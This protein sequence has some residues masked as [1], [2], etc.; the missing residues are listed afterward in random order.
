MTLGRIKARGVM[1]LCVGK[2]MEH[3]QQKMEHKNINQCR[4]RIMDG[5]QYTP[6][7]KLITAAFEYCTCIDMLTTLHN[8]AN[9]LLNTLENYRSKN[10]ALRGTAGL[11]I[12]TRT[13]TQTLPAANSL[14]SSGCLPNWDRFVRAVTLASDQH[15]IFCNMF[16]NVSICTCTL[17]IS[18][19]PWPICIQV[20]KKKIHMK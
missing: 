2:V 11:Q 3:K 6:D 19:D 20:R 4:F 9:K 17:S 15:N 8:N 14:W 18:W 7:L 12:N 13:H 16:E 5:W 1:G 10:R